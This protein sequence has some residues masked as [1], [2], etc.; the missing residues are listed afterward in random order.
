MSST[1]L[2]RRDFLR[3]SALATGAVA[4]GPGFW[5]EALA[6]PATPGEG[7][8]G[9]LQPPDVNGLMLPD[10]FSSREVVRG[11]QLVPGTDYLFHR[12]PDGQ[13]TYATPDG[14]FILVSNS[15][16]LAADG[17]GASAIRFR[18]DDSIADAYRILAGTNANCAGGATPWGTWMSC[19]EYDVGPQELEGE[20]EDRVPVPPPSAGGPT[21]GG[22]VWECDPTGSSTAVARPA[23]GKF[24]HEAVAV[25]PV[26]QQLY[27][28]E[29]QGDGGLY[30]FTPS[31]YPD[32]SEGLLE[33]ARV[34]AGGRVS[35]VEVPDP[36]AT[37]GGPTRY[38]I[39]GSAQFE[40]GEG[41][42]YDAGV[43][44]L[45]TTRDS[46]VHAY[47]TRAGTLDV[48]YD[49][50]ELSDPPLEDPD[51]ITVSPFGDLFVCE[52]DGGDDPL[53][54]VLITPDRIVARFCKLTG[55]AHA[56]SEL[57]GVTF[58]PS[59][60]RMLFSSQRGFGDGVIFEVVGPFRLPPEAQ[61]PPPGPALALEVARRIRSRR[62]RRRGLPIALTLDE[63]AEVAVSLS[64][65]LKDRGSGDRRSFILGR[66]RR[67][68]L[69]RGS[70]ALRLRL[71]RRARRRLRA[72]RR[73]LR[74]TIEVTLVRSDGRR[75]R[76]E[77]T[78]LI[79]RRRRQR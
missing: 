62:L 14:G 7:P 61:P 12:F 55:E 33:I 36:S 58:D 49:R 41:I 17:A 6:A 22:Q 13:A 74:A 8:Y 37:T 2:P 26:G 28:S 31:D 48:V 78:L 75:R 24:S 45:A 44:Y 69:R 53:D 32:A 11:R 21:V 5:R 29:D 18:S 39:T 52:D 25:D 56:G 35:W 34:D 72:R 3:A 9:P 19:E 38:Q 67:R 15:E 50:A 54:I 51:N 70:H 16:T 63:R 76:I 42:W 59:G 64:A 20:I 30:R 10:G 23:M 77:R 65:R 46:K 68:R 79:S 1:R 47:D 4:F 66:I 40:R 73:P 71:S 27:L 43:V 60:R 57:T